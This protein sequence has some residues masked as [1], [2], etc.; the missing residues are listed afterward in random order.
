MHFDITRTAENR[1]T[2]RGVKRNGS[3]AIASRAEDRNFDSLFHAGFLGGGNGGN[4]V[5]FFA[6]AVA[7]A[8][9]R[10]LQTFI[11]EKNLLADRPEKFLAAIDAGNL[12]VIEIGFIRANF[13]IGL[14]ENIEFKL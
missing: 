5:V 11:A 1:A 7:A 13:L 10:I 6:F 4:A 2:L 3:S 12:S 14:V 8:F 9:R